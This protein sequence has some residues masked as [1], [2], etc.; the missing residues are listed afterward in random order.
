MNLLH[1]GGLYLKLF[2]TSVED[3]NIKHSSSSA[4]IPIALQRW[5]LDPFPKSYSI[6]SQSLQ[7]LRILA[8]DKKILWTNKERQK[9]DISVILKQI[10]GSCKVSLNLLTCASRSLSIFKHRNDVQTTFSSVPTKI[11]RISVLRS[12]VLRSSSA[13]ESCIVWGAKQSLSHSR[14]DIGSD[15]SVEEDIY[16]WKEGSYRKMELGIELHCEELW[17]MLSSPDITRLIR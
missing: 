9:S 13:S 17:Y 12:S 16:V 11:H 15:N 8:S 10:S 5:V 3:G 7:I 14:K 6:S 1:C 2:K 4:S